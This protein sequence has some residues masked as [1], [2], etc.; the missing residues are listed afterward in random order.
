MIDEALRFLPGLDVFTIMEN[1][2][3][4]RKNEQ[5]FFF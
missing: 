3:V 2:M 5:T 1:L 4:N